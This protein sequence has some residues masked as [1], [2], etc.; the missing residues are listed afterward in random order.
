MTRYCF[1]G[2]IASFFRATSNSWASARTVSETVGGDPKAVR[3][4]LK[5]LHDH[6]HVERRG[7]ALAH[8]F[9]WN[10]D[11]LYKETRHAR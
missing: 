2:R 4:E 9:R 5:T 11:A 3:Q 8:E 7:K 10:P 1:S 6:G